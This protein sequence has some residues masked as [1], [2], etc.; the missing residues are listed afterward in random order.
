MTRF[1]RSEKHP[2]GYKLEELLMHLRADMIHRCETI[3]QDHRPEALHVMNNNLKIM[4]F[5]SEAI[6][7]AFDSTKVLDK[8][9]GPSQAAHGGPP[10]I[11]KIDEKA[12]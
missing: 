10:R 4:R 12:A 3:A 2:E 5:L 9:F 6:D 11:G 7:L 8:A 1:L